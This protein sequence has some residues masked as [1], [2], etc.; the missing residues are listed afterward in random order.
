MFSMPTQ[1]VQV[2]SMPFSS[3]FSSS[4]LAKGVILARAGGG[5]GNG[6]SPNHYDQM[7]CASRVGVRHAMLEGWSVSVVAVG[8]FIIVVVSGVLSGIVLFFP[9]FLLSFFNPSRSFLEL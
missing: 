7:E 5:G 2:T 3:A 9:F 1:Q 8:M 6:G 4:S